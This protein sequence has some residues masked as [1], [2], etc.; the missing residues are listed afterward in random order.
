M[1]VIKKEELQGILVRGYSHLPAACYLLL[2]VKSPKAVKAWISANGHEFTAGDNRGHE[3]ALNIAFTK[4]GLT[5]L[6]L[7]DD[8]MATFPFE[9]QDGMDTPH[10]QSL[11]GDYG[12]SDPANW[13]W[14]GKN[15][16]PIHV[17]LLLYATNNATLARQYTA[18]RSQWTDDPFEE[19]AKL[20]TK[21]ITARKEHFGFHDGISQP[22]IKGLGREQEPAENTVAAGEFILGYPNEYGQFTSSPTVSPASDRSNLLSPARTSA[23]AAGAP[24]LKDLGR[25]GSYLVFR[26][27]EQDVR[28]F[29]DFMEDKTRNGDGSCNPAEMIALASKTVGRWPSGTSLEL[30]PEKDEPNKDNKNNF[31]YIPHDKEGLVCPFGAHVRRTNPRD[32]INRGDST[33]VEVSKKHR[34]LRRGRSYGAPL[35]A[36]MQPE[37]IIQCKDDGSTR[38]LYFICL[39]ADLGRQFEFIQNFWINNPKFDGLYDERDP[40]T[41][42]HSN[43]QEN[44]HTG[45]VGI[46]RDK[47]RQ[48]FT[49]LPEFVT[50]K[51]GSYFFLPGMKALQYISSL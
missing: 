38:G 2:K 16:Q 47:L 49:D 1:E 9:F 26:Q 39:N 5:T 37:D 28:K 10:K 44:R 34:I 11:L 51:G 14:G 8:S 41:G 6:G 35:A 46:P 17:L 27:L 32:S 21:E 18:L 45:T 24:Q 43:P 19:I 22:A 3:S 42:N 29:W 15:N 20:D 50:L 25:H 36:S 31:N 23:A 40:I 7:G 12:N 13:S 4:E 33:S 30:S 48:R